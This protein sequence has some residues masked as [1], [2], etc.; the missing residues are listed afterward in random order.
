MTRYVMQLPLVML[1]SGSQH[2][3][4]SDIAL[5]ASMIVLEV[6]ERAVVHLRSLV[7]I[8]SNNVILEIPQGKKELVSG[9]NHVNMEEPCPVWAE[10]R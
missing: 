10:Y 3:A 7:L 9:R 1:S 8:S 6:P 5:A 4:K 2:G